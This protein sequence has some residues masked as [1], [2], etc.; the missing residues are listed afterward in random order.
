MIEGSKRINDSYAEKL[1]NLKNSGEDCSKEINKIYAMWSED[2]VAQN[3][4]LK[5]IVSE[6]E[7]ETLEKFE[8]SSKM[9]CNCSVLSSENEHLKSIIF[10]LENR[11][12]ERERLKY[13]L[14]KKNQE[15]FLLEKTFIL[16]IEKDKI[17]TSFAKLKNEVLEELK[18]VNIVD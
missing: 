13:D 14:L 12:R 2:L 11:I 10:K 5:E 7:R 8:F 15:Q 16:T 3:E 1:Q 6:L 4:A 9:K 17:I 18:C